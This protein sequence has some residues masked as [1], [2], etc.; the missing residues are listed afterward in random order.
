M[1]NAYIV[2]LSLS[3]LGFVILAAASAYAY[4]A[5][6]KHFEAANRMIE[7]RT[8]VHDAASDLM[9][10]L[11]ADD[12]IDLA[13]NR[14][15]QAGSDAIA[16]TAA[17]WAAQPQPA[18]RD[19]LPL[20]VEDLRARV[21]TGT[22][23]Y[24]E[25]LRTFNGRDSLRDA[26]EEALDLALYLRQAIEEREPETP[27]ASA[28]ISGLTRKRDADGAM[29]PDS[30]PHFPSEIE[31][32]SSSIPPDGI[33]D[34]RESMVREV[35]RGGVILYGVHATMIDDAAGEMP[36]PWGTYPDIPRNG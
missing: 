19:V 4:I 7:A 31:A 10:L 6:R 36:G 15:G 21:A 18:R 5:A 12:R 11:R 14:E 26:Y 9:Q 2:A 13:G 25:P 22:A 3:A 24:G 16:R 8:R 34:N 32:Q 27:V 17:E 1:N 35:W 29:P 30:Y 28:S 33:Y 23:E 20:V